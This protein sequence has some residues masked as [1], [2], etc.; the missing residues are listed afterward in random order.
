VIV[1]DWDSLRPQRH[2][3]RRQLTADA[4]VCLDQ[5]QSGSDI[6]MR[7]QIIQQPKQH[8]LG[9]RL[10]IDPQFDRFAFRTQLGQSK[11]GDPKFFQ[12]PGRA[13]VLPMEPIRL[14]RS[15]REE[16]AEL[17]FGRQSSPDEPTFDCDR[18]VAGTH[19]HESARGGRF[20]R[21]DQARHA[22]FP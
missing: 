1:A 2:H 20:C 22:R 9:V 14:R 12:T 18:E 21:Q 19:A 10:W 11:I 3:F 13:I 7:S 6:G 16:R 15:G 5:P 8:Q 17:R 4:E